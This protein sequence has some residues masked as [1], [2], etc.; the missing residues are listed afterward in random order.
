MARNVLWSFLRDM[1]KLLLLLFVIDQI[2]GVDILHDV[3]RKGVIAVTV[4]V[5]VANVV[6]P[7]I[8]GNT[9]AGP[10]GGPRRQKKTEVGKSAF[11]EWASSE[12]QGWRSA[13]EDATCMV[14]SLT[15]PLSHQALFAVF[16]GHGGAQVSAIASRE[17]PKVVSAC[18][19]NLLGEPGEPPGG[20]CPG[21]SAPAAAAAAAGAAGGAAEE[22]ERGAASANSAPAAAVAA[23]GPRRR[24]ATNGVVEKA[25]HVAMLTMDGLLRKG[26]GL[27]KAAAAAAQGAEAPEKPNAFN[28]MG[29]TAIVVLVDCGEESALLGRPR[30]ITV[31]NCGDSRAVLCRKGNAVELSQ[32]H[33]PELPSEE[34]RIRRAGGHVKLI[35]PCHRIDGWGLNL[36]RALG[37]FH[38]KARPDLPVEEQKVIA[39]PEIY[40]LDLTDEDEFL[41][42]ACDGVFEL[43]TSQQAIDLVR[44]RLKEG[45]SVEKAAEHLLDR[46]CSQNLVKTRGRGGDNCSTIVIRLLQ[47]ARGGA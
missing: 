8:E 3:T 24:L 47:R 12:M 7:L 15:E 20:P 33:K 28:L 30:R 36:S 41:V 46:S 19:T 35:G 42:L 31:A 38:Y 43:N 37:D 11:L 25:L 23:E 17:L 16:D 18:A 9:A 6:Q 32:D 44:Q 40:A 1:Y 27:A 45:A 14:P 22:D 5:V 2:P 29:S 10:K 34:E 21:G 39:V 4:C 26:G 13:M